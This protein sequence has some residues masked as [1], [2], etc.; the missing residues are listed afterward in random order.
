MIWRVDVLSDGEWINLSDYATE[1]AAVRSIAGRWDFDAGPSWIPRQQRME[2][3]R[4]TYRIVRFDAVAVAVYKPDA[5]LQPRSAASGTS[6][7]VR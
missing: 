6:R 1:A 3:A 7:G 4:K 5:A 2:E